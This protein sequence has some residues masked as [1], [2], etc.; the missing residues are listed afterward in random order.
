MIKR[1]APAGG[2]LAKGA[3]STPPTGS[4]HSILSGCRHSHHLLLDVASFTQLRGDVGPQVMAA[5]GQKQRCR[6][7][8]ISASAKS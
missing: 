2:I 8:M 6:G 7:R 5:G 3:G 4:R 1:V